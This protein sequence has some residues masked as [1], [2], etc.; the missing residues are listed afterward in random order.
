MRS[1]EF[2]LLIGLAAGLLQACAVATGRD[3]PRCGRSH[4]LRIVDLN[5]DPDPIGQ[6][7]LVRDWRVTL[8]ADAGGECATRLWIEERPGNIVVAT[9]RIF[10]L[11]PG[12]NLIPIEPAGR[13]RFS[14]AQHCF[15]VIADIEGTP[16]P[17]DAAR[18]FCARQ[19]GNRWTVRP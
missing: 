3:G 7:Q 18:S 9:E 17:I 12:I 8:Q 10:R 6:G 14:R 2:V 16:R 1:V 5:M 4:V 19:V 11:R 13:Y 15:T